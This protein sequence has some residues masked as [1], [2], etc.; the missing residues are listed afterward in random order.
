MTRL[1][2]TVW[3]RG[4]PL[5]LWLAVLVLFCLPGIIARSASAPSRRVTAL[6]P[7]FAVV[8]DH[9]VDADGDVSAWLVQA[10]TLRLPRP[11][12]VRWTH[13]DVQGVLDALVSVRRFGV[14]QISLPPPAGA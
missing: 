2:G 5:G 7:V 9:P 13:Q 6:P 1:A 10:P 8:A 14:T 12:L 3:R 4:D 11:V